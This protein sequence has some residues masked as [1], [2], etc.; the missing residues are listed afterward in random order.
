M[1][2]KKRLQWPF[3][4]VYLSHDL[5]AMNSLLIHY[6]EYINEKMI[7]WLAQSKSQILRNDD[8]WQSLTKSQSQN[9]I[10]NVSS[11]HKLLT[12]QLIDVEYRS[13]KVD[14]ALFKV[15][16]YLVLSG[17]NGLG[18]NVQTYLVFVSWFLSP[19]WLLACSSTGTLDPIFGLLP[20]SCNPPHLNPLIYIFWSSLTGPHLP[21]CC[22]ICPQQ[23]WGWSGRRYGI[24]VG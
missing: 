2:S 5:I 10:S 1:C 23:A 13:P 20:I 16:S 15:R 21:V 3:T 12:I 4:H 8:Y 19:L 14:Q 11:I 17:K 7:S 22:G 18:Y 6:N 24:Y 9:L